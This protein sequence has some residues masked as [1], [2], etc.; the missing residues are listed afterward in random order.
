MVIEVSPLTGALIVIFG[1]GSP[2]WIWLLIIQFIKT[3]R[4]VKS[5]GRI[6]SRSYRHTTTSDGSISMRRQY[7]Y[8]VSFVDKY[9]IERKE[10]DDLN[11]TTKREV[12]ATVPIY[13][14]PHYPERI[15]I[16]NAMRFFFPPLIFIVFIMIM[17][18]VI[19]VT[20]S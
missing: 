14:D 1:L 18:I 5:E 12:N 15:K 3:K 2:F 8:T 19:F 10:V 9:G 7:Q 17:G 20:N 4:Y 16:G 13:Y 11:T 6:V